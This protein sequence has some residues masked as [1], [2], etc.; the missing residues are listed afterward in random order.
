MQC[1]ERETQNKKKVVSVFIILVKGSLLG[2]RSFQ[3]KEEHIIINTDE[4]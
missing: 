2:D 3:W 1:T 4:E